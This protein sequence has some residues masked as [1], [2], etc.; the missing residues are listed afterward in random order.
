[1]PVLDCCAGLFDLR[2][3]KAEDRS[4]AAVDRVCR[5][6]HQLAALGNNFNAVRERNN[7]CR[8]ERSVLAERKAPFFSQW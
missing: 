2:V 4:H 1:M 7:A 3:L 8:C 6:L 5:V